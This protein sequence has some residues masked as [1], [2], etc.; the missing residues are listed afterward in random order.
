MPASRSIAVIKGLS[1]SI[2]CWTGAYLLVTIIAFGFS[3]CSNKNSAP[4]GILS[5]DEMAK[6]LTDFYLKESK[7]TGL[8]LSQDSALVLFE[9]YRSKYVEETS[10]PDSVIDQSYQYYLERPKEMGEIYDRIIDSLALKEQRFKPPVL[11]P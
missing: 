11:A 6:V 4:D 2:G 8:H 7:I 3:S 1:T 5:K 9:Y 10:I